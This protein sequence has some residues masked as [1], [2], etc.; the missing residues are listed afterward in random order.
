MIIIEIFRRL[1]KQLDQLNKRQ[2]ARRLL[3][4]LDPRLLKDI[5]ISRAEALNEAT[6]PFW[7]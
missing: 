3:K 4:E 5:G 2:R 7:K 6:K 1:L